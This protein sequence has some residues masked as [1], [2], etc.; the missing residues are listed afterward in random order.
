M[1]RIFA[2]SPFERAS[3]FGR[4]LKRPLQFC[5]P[6]HHVLKGRGYAQIIPLSIVQKNRTPNLRLVRIFGAQLLSSGGSDYYCVSIFRS[7]RFWTIGLTFEKKFRPVSP[8]TRS[9]LVRKFRHGVLIP[10]AFVFGMM[11]AITRVVL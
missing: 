6:P 3:K 4:T 5:R 1:R 10:I 9:T 7:I 2:Q 11:T 8:S